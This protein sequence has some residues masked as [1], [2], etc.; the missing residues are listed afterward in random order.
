MND[1]YV[2]L[3][4]RDRD[5]VMSFLS[6]HPGLN[7]IMLNNIQMFGMDGGESP[8]HGDYFGRRD[9]SGLMAVGAFFNL[10]SLFLYSVSDDAI[11]GMSDYVLGLGRVPSFINS[12]VSFV[13]KLLEGFR[14]KLGVTFNSILTDQMVLKGSIP[15]GIDT[16]CA[17][18]SRESDLDILV[19][20][21]TRLEEELFG[22]V[23]MDARSLRELLS[24][25]VRSGTASVAEHDGE[26]VSKAEATVTEGT[27]A[28]VGGV[29]TEPDFRGRGFA[30]ACV[31]DLCR[32]L[33]EQVDLVA[34]SVEREN[35]AS[36]RLYQK[37]G[38]K[39]IDD[40]MIATPGPRT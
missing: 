21:Q 39:K 26:V 15:E 36:L 27:G 19:R 10:G 3:D 1:K 33:L 32:Q 38:F 13:R 35:P 18:P 29:Y 37:I 34:I 5:E 20:M 24:W 7:L 9:E 31:G 2:R 4:S 6:G 22:R 23:S 16:E 40:W 12:R 11:E 8:F 30:T 14:G 28:N 25:Q 17:R